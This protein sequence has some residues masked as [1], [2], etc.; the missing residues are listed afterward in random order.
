MLT[1]LV[2][3]HYLSLISALTFEDTISI[4]EELTLNQQDN[5]MM[6]SNEQDYELIKVEE[7]HI[8][9]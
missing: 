7:R 4:E 1:V 5:I 6:K 2:I 9:F 3:L 8:F